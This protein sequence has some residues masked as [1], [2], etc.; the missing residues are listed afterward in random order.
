MNSEEICLLVFGYMRKHTIDHASDTT[1]PIPHDLSRLILLFHGKHIAGCI[2]LLNLGNTGC[3][4]AITQ[5]LAHTPKGFRAFCL[6]DAYKQEINVKNPLGMQGSLIRAFASTLHNIWDVH[7]YEH[8]RSKAIKP[9]SLKRAIGT[10][11]PQFAGYAQHDAMELLAFLLDGCHE[12]CNRILNKPYTPAIEANGRSDKVVAA[13]CWRIYKMR[14]DSFIVDTFQAQ[15]KCH[16][17]CPQCDYNS[18]TFDPYMYLSV[19]IPQRKDLNIYDCLDAFVEESV[20]NDNDLWYCKKC[21]EH[22]HGVKKCDLWSLPEILII[23][24]KRY[25]MNELNQRVKNDIAIQYP[26]HGLDLHKY[27]INDGIMNSAIYDLYAI[28]KHLGGIGGGHNVSTVKHIEDE[29]WYCF[30]DSMVRIAENADSDDLISHNAYI[31]FYKRLG[32]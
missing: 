15:I 16:V 2:G 23:H 18:I 8:L 25:V 13:L 9:T 20:L 12:D 6:S 24:L 31:L 10:F 21:K 32:T 27:V 28:E 11:A 3:M 30:N 22:V 14:N 29:K 1:E 7:H 19:P 5:C 17:I 26:I 4:N